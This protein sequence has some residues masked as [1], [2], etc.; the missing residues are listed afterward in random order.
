MGEPKRN[1]SILKGQEKETHGSHSPVDSEI[2]LG[3][4]ISRGLFL[5]PGE[6]TLIRPQFQF[7]G[8]M[9]GSSNP[10]GSWLLGGSPFFEVEPHGNPLLWTKMSVKH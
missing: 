10:C 2:I 8:E 5:G 9:Y 4:H 3:T 1:I 6:E 7:L